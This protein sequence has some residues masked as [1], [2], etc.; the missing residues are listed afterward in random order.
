MNV[1]LVQREGVDLYQTLL[2]SETSRM[3]L[4]FYRPS[5][6]DFGVVVRGASLG[7]SLSLVSELKWY[8][9]RYVAL[10]LFEF[11]DGQYCT[12]ALAR[13]AY[14][15]EIR[16]QEPWPFRRLVGI[17]DGHLEHSVVLDAPASPEAYAA[18]AAGMDTVLEV[19]ITGAE[20]GE[21]ED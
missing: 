10:V 7:G 20:A 8:I 21:K 2:A 1:L 17:R 6:L 15:R 11:A 5:A 16:L 19:L 12:H 18:F 14:E 13:E 9:R 4:R 3:I